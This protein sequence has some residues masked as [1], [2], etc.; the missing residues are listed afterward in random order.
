MDTKQVIVMRKDLNMR[1]GK[2]VAQGSHASLAN[3]L[4]ELDYDS[5]VASHEPPWF[6]DTIIHWLENSFAKVCVSV[7]SEAE[8]LSIYDQATQAGLL[9]SL[10]K[11]SGRTEFGGVPTYTCLCVGPNINE[12]IDKITGHLTLL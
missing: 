4:K 5:C 1:K 11:D 12:D 6:N 10:I 8:L 3:I 9:C 7:N 2:M